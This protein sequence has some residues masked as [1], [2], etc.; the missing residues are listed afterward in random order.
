MGRYRANL[1]RRLRD[2]HVL[3]SEAG[4]ERRVVH[5][6]RGVLGL[7]LGLG[8]GVRLGLWFGLGEWHTAATDA[9]ETLR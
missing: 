1:W 3:G 2:E 9:G 7:G 8:I 4:G 6:V 5:L